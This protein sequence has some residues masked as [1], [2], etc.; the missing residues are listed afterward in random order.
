MFEAF[1]KMVGM[2][3]DELGEDWLWLTCDGY[4]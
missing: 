3:V 4:W 2:I 1:F